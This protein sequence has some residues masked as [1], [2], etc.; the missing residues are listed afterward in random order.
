MLRS[1]CLATAIGSLPH[2]DAKEA[3]DLV[4]RHLNR[5]PFWPQLPRRSYIE[6]MMPQYSEGMPGVI[7]DEENKKIHINADD[8]LLKEMEIFYETYMSEELEPFRITEKYAAGFYEFISRVKD[9][10]EKI[11]AVKGHITGP[12][13]WGLTVTD[14]DNRASYYNES[15]RDCMLKML[16]RKARW[17]VRALKGLHQNVIIF[18]DEPYLQSIGA[19][20]VSLKRE[21]VIENLNEVI[22]GIKAEGGV[23]GIH[24]CGNT[25]WELL[26]ETDTD[27][28]SFD[29]YEYAGSLALY[30]KQIAEF[31]ERGGMLAWGVVPASKDVLKEDENSLTRKLRDGMR[32]LTKKGIRENT[33][34]EACLI[35]P[36]CGAGS[37]GTE[38][39]DAMLRLTS[40]LSSILRGEMEKK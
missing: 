34:L 15:F 1:K 25:D 21:E 14:Q 8:S 26:S 24:C 36:A 9:L 7:I 27:I 13:T 20:F 17:Q 12:I 39:A 31:L 18:I 19:S 33:L 6:G 22:S 2:T 37:L 40:R 16:E 23:A 32:L 11:V 30:P 3:I 35:T 28:I 29:A 4:F 10:N 38:D 5:V